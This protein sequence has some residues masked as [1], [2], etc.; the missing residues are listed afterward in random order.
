MSLEHLQATVK[1]R[2]GGAYQA[3]SQAFLGLE[4]RLG[5]MSAPHVDDRNQVVIPEAL[6]EPVKVVRAYP[7]YLVSPNEIIEELENGRNPNL[8][9]IVL[10]VKS[11]ESIPSPG[12]LTPIGGKIRKTATNEEELPFQAAVRE[13]SEE[14]TLRIIPFSEHTAG[15]L[16]YKSDGTYIYTIPDYV[17]PRQVQIV[18]MPVLPPNIAKAHI[19]HEDEDKLAAIETVS[20]AELQKAVKEGKLGKRHMIESGAMVDVLSGVQFVPQEKVKR[21]EQLQALV[22]FFSSIERVIIQQMLAG[23]LAPYVREGLQKENILD[24]RHKSMKIRDALEDIKINIPDERLAIDYYHI[25]SA[26]LGKDTARQIMAKAVDQLQAELFTGFYRQNEMASLMQRREPVSAVKPLEARP[27]VKARKLTDEEKRQVEDKRFLH[28]MKARAKIIKERLN[29]A[30]L[31]VDIYDAISLVAQVDAPTARTT[32]LSIAFTG[33][34]KDLFILAARRSNKDRVASPEDY[35]LQAMLSPSAEPQDAARFLM[36][37]N[38]MQ[39]EAFRLIHMTMGITRPDL[40]RIWG[41]V[42]S[43]YAQFNKDVQAEADPATYSLYSIKGGEER[44]EVTDA[45]FPELIGLAMHHWDP[46]VRFESSRKLLLFFKQ[47][48]LM[49]QYDEAVSRGKKFFS[50]VVRNLYGDVFTHKE[51]DGKEVHEIRGRED[52]MVLV[53]SKPTKTRISTTRKGFETSAEDINDYYSYNIAL[54]SPESS[55]RSRI[56]ETD[57]MVDELLAYMRETGYDVTIIPGSDK[58]TYDFAARSAEGSVTSEEMRIKSGKRTGS[59]GDFII[60]RKMVIQAIDSKGQVYRCEFA[61]Y[62][63]D[64][65]PVELKSKGFMGLIEKL[66]DDR[67]YSQRRAHDPIKLIYSDSSSQ[68]ESAYGVPSHY[69]LAFPPHNYPHMVKVKKAGKGKTDN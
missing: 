28:K 65:T 62:P 60:R 31:G 57:K 22:S 59:K 56:K 10:G 42:S 52:R 34:L 18:S 3:L 41:E 29:S 15:K 33:F 20:P 44:N 1:E 37:H 12:M 21:D 27:A 4:R 58:N 26:S 49:P 64:T 8:I 9:R 51:Y 43:Y 53:D 7:W 39:K 13:V 54:V 50:M 19:L 66:N 68:R 25:I 38:N 46:K 2:V 67:R 45:T 24:S 63:Y 55:I 5:I 69:E 14:T 16:H 17:Q 61:F 6:H 32:H 36:F 23:K 35:A 48:G 11:G 30:N 47:L 40:E